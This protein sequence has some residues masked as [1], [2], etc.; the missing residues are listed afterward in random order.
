MDAGSVFED[1]LW[2]VGVAEQERGKA[3]AGAEGSSGGVETE[4][5]ETIAVH[6]NRKWENQAKLVLKDVHR[7][8]RD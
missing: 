7:E 2:D 8:E 1:V 4:R 5:A 6:Y 3:G